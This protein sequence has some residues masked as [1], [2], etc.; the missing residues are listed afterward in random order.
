MEPSPPSAA[1]TKLKWGLIAGGVLLALC[2][3]MLAA[4][5]GLTV[6]PRPAATPATVAATTCIACR[7]CTSFAPRSQHAFPLLRAALQYA[8]VKMS[9][10]TQVI[11]SGTL[12]DKSG[13]KVVGE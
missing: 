3:L 13:E 7:G 10:E 2:L 1:K 12:M 6:S 8:V 5:A 4:N 9:Q 11:S